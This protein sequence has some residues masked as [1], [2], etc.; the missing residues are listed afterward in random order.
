MTDGIA[1]RRGLMAFGLSV[2]LAVGVG[3]L[4]AMPLDRVSVAMLG[5]LFLLITSPILLRWHHVLLIATWNAVIVFPVSTQPRIWVAFAGISLGISLLA[6]ILSKK[7]KLLFIPSVAWPLLFLLIV[8][9][10]TA[11]LTGGFGGGE[12]WGQ[13]RYFTAFAAILGFFAMTAQVIPKDRRMLYACL[14][15]GA[16]I[17]HVVQDLLFLAGPSFYFL[18]SIFGTDV[19][20]SQ[21]FSTD[22]LVR[23][24]GFAVGGQAACLLML[25]Q[26][27]IRGLCDFA[28]WWRLGVFFFCFGF[29][30]LGGFR[31]VI[32]VDAL[33]IL[34]VFFYEGLF[35]TR[36]AFILLLATTLL[37]SLVVGFA[38][39]LPLS[40]QRTLSVLPIDLD[41]RAER[42][43]AGT[44]DWRWQIW[45]VMY[46]QI[47]R[48]LLL[49]KGYAYSGTDAYLMT[50]ATLR[51]L[52][53]SYETIFIS[54]AYHSGPLTLIIPFGIFGVLA[55][56][57]FCV[58]GFRILY[59]NYRF[60]DPAI[61]KVNVFLVSYFSAYLVFF[62]SVY[63]QFDQDLYIFT[64]LVGFSIALNGGVAKRKPITNSSIGSDVED[65]R[66]LVI[67][68]VTSA[69]SRL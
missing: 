30:L 27:G 60:G 4:L 44:S 57:W 6:Y 47:P 22:E 23:F 42:D 38:N 62:L 54:G 55:F 63:G 31:S 5:S 13:K 35:R 53:P 18:F 19:V 69:D 16:G 40:I 24:A 37:L 45:K 56:A 8:M 17:T 39:R 64:G 58:S 12:M 2:P 66:A 14:F 36:Y 67:P 9:A 21:A 1:W 46:P 43:A 28:K 41:P 61:K 50:E 32:V 25:M 68:S 52:A 49:G 7:T 34:A 3:Y 65:D 51:G 10:V 48:Y 29:S 11:R 26:Y 20:A 15:F 59:L 33:V